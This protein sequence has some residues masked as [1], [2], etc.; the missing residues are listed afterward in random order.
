MLTTVRAA[1][2]AVRA[3]ASPGAGAA[4]VDGRTAD[5]GRA[6]DVAALAGLV[7]AVVDGARSDVAVLDA[8]LVVVP[9][10]SRLKIRRAKARLYELLSSPAPG[11]LTD[12]PGSRF[13]PAE[14]IVGVRTWRFPRRYEVHLHTGGRLK[15]RWGAECDQVGDGWA[16]LEHLLAAAAA[17][18]TPGSAGARPPATAARG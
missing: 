7:N 17:G 5:R 18:G 2:A 11:R 6:G 16:A 4:P 8:G 9:G 15:L 13:I 3:G 1:P 12:L 14:E 10:L